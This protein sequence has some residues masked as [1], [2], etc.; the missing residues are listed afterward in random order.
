MHLAGLKLFDTLYTAWSYSS[1]TGASG[2]KLRM[3]SKVVEKTISC[4]VAAKPEL[5]L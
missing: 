1:A 4:Q 2:G 3:R 5:I